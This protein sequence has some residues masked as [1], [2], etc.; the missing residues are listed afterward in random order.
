MR[1]L[2]IFFL[3][4]IFILSLTTGVSAEFFSDVI[5]TSPNGIWT[6]SRA[7]TTLNAAIT[8]VGS[9]QRTVK[10]VRPQ[11][12]TTLTVPA[13]VTLEFERDGAINNS[14]QLT[15]NTKNIKAPDRQ[16]FTGAGDVD[17][18]AGSTVRSSWFSNFYTAATLTN[19]DTVTLI[20][21]KQETVNTSCAI[22]NNVVLKWESPL[23][24][25]VSAGNTISNIAKVEAGDY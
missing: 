5:V 9:N 17:F 19:D 23:L 2:K 3:T 24:L 15:I 18:A 13:N 16:I 25:G 22:G 14:G 8:A 10:I 21:S 7:Y 12:V 6:D 11:T 4:L 1:K 20:V